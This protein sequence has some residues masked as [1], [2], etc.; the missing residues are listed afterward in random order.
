MT[1]LPVIYRLVARLLPAEF[2][3]RHGEAMGAQLE[4]ERPR[5]GSPLPSAARFWA[6][7][8]LDVVR[9]VLPAWR[10]ALHPAIPPRGDA[11]LRG[12]TSSAMDNWI[13]DTQ[14]GMRSL[15]RQPL[16]TGMCLAA[17]ALGMGANAAVFTLV[18]EILLRP[19]PF[20]DPHELAVMH[21]EQPGANSFSGF[22]FPEVVDY[23]DRAAG[24]ET[25][26][27]TSGIG[28][29]L[30]DDEQLRIPSQ[31]S[32][33]EYF[34]V[35]AVEP[36]RGRVFTRQEAEVGG[37][38]AVVVVSY[39]FWQRRFAGADDLLG[40]TIELGGIPMT[41]IGIMPPG[42]TGPFIGFPMEAWVPLSVSDRLRPGTELASR[43][44]Q[45]FEVFVRLADGYELQAAEESLN[46]VAAQ[47]EQQFPA[48]NRSRR[49]S[50][51]PVTGLDDSLRG[52]VLGFLGILLTL[53]GLVLVA[54]CLNVGNLLLARSQARAPEIAT[55][56]ALGASRLRLV[57]QL[58]TETLL[59]FLLGAALATGLAWQVN[60]ALRRFVD[61]LEAP[62]GFELALDPRVLALTA[63]ATLLTALATGLSP[64]VRATRGSHARMLRG[65]RGG[66]DS[67]HLR[68]IFVVGQVAASLVLLTVAGLF[69]R[70]LA[71][72]QELDP[73][74]ETGDLAVATA[75]LPADRYS[76]QQAL[77][78]FEQLERAVEAH[79]TVRAVALAQAPPLGVSRT[80]IAVD[81]DG[82]TPPEGQDAFFIDGNV[83]G[84]SYFAAVGIEIVQGR[85]FGDADGMDGR[86]VGIVNQRLAEQFWDERSSIGRVLRLDG[87]QIELIGVVRDTRTRI[88]DSD[89]EP[90]LYLPH[91][92]NP[93]L[94]QSLV[95]RSSATPAELS[96]LL[97]EE[98]GGLDATLAAPQARP[99]SELIDSFLLPQRVA[100]RAAGGL[101]LIGLLLAL[102]GVYGIVAYALSLRRHELAIR[103]A[104]GGRPG[105]VTR[106]V[107]RAGT[108]IV[109][110]GTL[111][112]LAIALLLGPLLRSF[113][114]GVAPADPLTLAAAAGGLGAAALA[115]AWIPARRAA[116]I[117]PA[118]SLRES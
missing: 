17:I 64:A 3:A 86:L 110:L 117:A 106:L 63:L 27:A 39:G 100:S 56:M 1:R 47:L 88:Q 35:F 4:Q 46:V 72:G 84:A 79:P 104:L 22:S 99:L 8:C 95:I 96:R 43:T 85:G 81:V 44:S 71:A 34:S 10:R 41:V 62:L 14:Y 109:G 87:R 93:Q 76:A 29:R 33:A 54:A 49:V 16:V 36:A 97:A 115:A 74:F 12:R 31:L 113:L 18:N 19:L 60:A 50:L 68:Q 11:T 91:S 107:L 23:R 45:P 2:R 92:Q 59:L 114:V 37:S 89:I 58:L 42:F 112:G 51:T 69:L 82:V 77:V 98:L 102:A 118:D 67:A 61:S 108:R 21:V 5:R 7:A 13:R 57:R 20:P 103:M 78:L 24:I 32:S 116:R 94:R 15:R 25:A 53:S 70:A 55:R 26:A 48:L 101:G 75:G 38:E 9:G 73:G 90:L 6:R 52:S 66:G 105:D 80:P 111:A 83:V 28:L 40:S 30:G 65:A